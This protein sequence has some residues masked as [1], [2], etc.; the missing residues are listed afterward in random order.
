MMALRIAHL[1]RRYG[2]SAARA[3]LLA[4]LIYGG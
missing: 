3:R 2:V 1:Q 4:R